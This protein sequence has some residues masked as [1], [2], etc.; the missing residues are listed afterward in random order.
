M[1]SHLG[2]QIRLLLLTALCLPSLAG[3]E[4]AARP[5]GA[6]LKVL[7][8]GDQ[9]HHRPAERAR[10][11][12]PLMAARGILVDY[13]E[14]VADLNPAVLRS[15]DALLVYA[16]IDQISSDQQRSLLDYVAGGGG[17][18]PLHCASFCFRNSPDYVKLVGA[19]FAS[20]GVGEFDTTIVVGDHPITQGLRTFKTWDET[21]VHRDHNPQDRLVLQVRGDGANAEPW[22]W[23]RQHGRG[24]VFYTA[25]GHD[26]R[27]WGEPGFQALIERGIRWAAGRS[28]VF[29]STPRPPKDAPEFTYTKAELPNYL[30]GEKWGTQGEPLA[31]MQQPLAPADSMRHMVLPSAEFSL[32]LFAAEPDIAKPIA[33]AWDHRGRLWIA[34]TVDYPN[35]L[36]REGQGHDRIKICQDTDGDGRADRFTVFADKLSI[37]TSLLCVRDGVIVHQAPHTLLLR[38]TNGDDV[39]DERQVLFSGWGTRD[40][41]AGPS[42]LRYGFDNWIYGI[43]GY[44]G[45]SGKVGTQQHDFR[46][47]F[48]RFRPDG[49]QIEFLRNT[50]NNSWGVG[51][52][53]EG[54]L[55]GSTANGCPSVYLPIANR[56]YEAVRGWAPTVLENIAAW[57]RYYPV[58]DK[59]RQMDWHGGFT[60]AAGHALYTARTYPPHYWNRAAFVTEPTG[61]LA[62]TLL[63][64]PRGADFVSHYAWNLAASF[65]QWTSPIA[66]EVGP[67]GQVWLIDWYN[68][69]IQHNP[70]PQGFKTGKGNAYETDLR[71]KTH[72]RIYRVVYTPGAP[73]SLTQLDPQDARQLTKALASDNLFWRL[74]AQR[75][76]VERGKPDVVPDLVALLADQRQDATGLSAGPVHAAW[77]LVGLAAL[78]EKQSPAARA[79]AQALAHPS[80][81]V[82]RNVAGALPHTR[83]SAKA[84][85]ES[86]QLRD[87]D[88][89]VRL[90]ALLA[91]AEMPASP[92]VARA[93][94]DSLSLIENLSDR[95]LSDALTAALARNDREALLSLAASKAVDHPRHAQIIARIA[96]HYARSGPVD[97]VG[98][99]VA[100]L[101]KAERPIA[102]TIVLGL[103]AGWPRDRAVAMN[104]TLDKSLAALVER[105]APAV[106]GPLVSL[107][108]TWGSKR[109]KEHAAKLSARWWATLDDNAQSD[110]ARGEAA[111]QVVAFQKSAAEPAERVLAII[112]PRASSELA[113]GLID[114]AVQ[115]ESPEVGAALAESLGSMTPAS[116][117]L[118]LRALLGRTAWT[119][120]LLDAIEGGQVQWAEISLDQ[121]Q[122]LAAHRDKRLAARAKTLLARGGGLPDADR[123]KVIEQLSSQ[124]LSGGNVAQGKLVFKEHCSKCHVYSGEGTK[125]GP[126]LTGM[127]V[128]P[129]RELLVHLLDPS[130]DVE[131]NYLQYTV[132]TDDGRSLVGLLAA[133]T[134][135]TIEIISPEAK[136]ELLLREN[137][138]ELVA[139]KKSLM[140]EG[141]EKQVTPGAL[142]DL[143]EY[144]TQRGRFLPLDLRKVATSTSTRGM[145]YDEQSDIER[146]V[147]DDWSPKTFAGVPFQLVDPQGDRVRNVV[148]LHGPQ[149][150]FPPSMPKQ[151]SLVCNAPAKAIHLLSGVSGWGYAGGTPDASVSM[152]VRLHYADGTSEDHPLKNGLHFADYIRVVD[153]PGSKLAFTLRGQQIRYLAIEPKRAEPIATIELVKGPDATAPVVMAVTV[154]TR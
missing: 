91:L 20:H 153:V 6:E 9:G 121:Q 29:D 19:Q 126:D 138:E 103:A 125:I 21:Y 55:F 68:Y 22:T 14:N 83:E 1:L 122:S 117:P 87:P 133:E 61:H 94:V 140:P 102:D 84:I 43:V 137:I 78:D 120:A 81:A 17:F 97:S 7:F 65:D 119:P 127:A 134:K 41:H 129:K 136:R 70:T 108:E 37:P 98:G 11:F 2:L 44:S 76:L 5:A 142:A 109:L 100:E 135:T 95:W 92:E 45:F 73:S 33:M 25:Y 99:L 106:Q 130:R 48:Y 123:Q 96:E 112:T 53:E 141:F 139:S 4:E 28:E 58:T 131:G 77:A 26:G 8:L 113:A 148:L 118:V 36:Q 60:A 150:K 54:H 56:H 24:R 147:F 82:R 116:R 40:T 71:D 80:A 88:F 46:T 30:P 47:G 23:V 12:V 57:N 13:T 75:L 10:Q 64:E 143:L 105:I 31:D 85:L 128:H 132:I 101:A 104:D 63:L 27:T 16:N 110:E 93:V 124:V 32:E 18:V 67:D 59:V 111:R 35:E 149:G 115:S 90:A 15:Y 79:M 3:A 39:A 38:D 89:Q 66:A 72:G 42:S 152:I 107:G 151:V 49:S 34:E 114:A 62:A 52:S 144:L 74:T 86:G 51:F 50:S 146:L 69:I 145:F 154:E